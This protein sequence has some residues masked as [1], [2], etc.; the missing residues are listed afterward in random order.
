MTVGG[1]A[2]LDDL[3]GNGGTVDDVGVAIFLCQFI[4]GE[5]RARIH[6][7][8]EHRTMINVHHG[9]IVAGRQHD[10]G[11]GFPIARGRRGD[12]LDSSVVHERLSNRVIAEDDGLPCA[13]HVH[14]VDL[15]QF[16]VALRERSAGK[17]AAKAHCQKEG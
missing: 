13:A 10:V 17:R 12:Q 8:V 4:D 3:L 2:N 6:E 5:Q 7:L 11:D 16:T 9:R 14:E 1:G 15:G